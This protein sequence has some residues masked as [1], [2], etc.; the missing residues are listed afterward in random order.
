MKDSFSHK[1]YLAS[2]HFSAEDGTLYGQ[3][4]GIDDLISFQ[5]ESV[6]ELSVAFHAAVQ[7]YEE[8]CRSAGKDPEKTLKGSFN[9]RLGPELHRAAHR[10]AVCEGKSLNQFVQDAVAREVRERSPEYGTGRLQAAAPKP[11]RVARG[12]GRT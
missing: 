8:L 4:E 12:H 5:G 9:V 10:Q 3:I 6:A 2:V 1:G 7:D 11:K